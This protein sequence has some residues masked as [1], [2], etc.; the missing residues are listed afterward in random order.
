MYI[1]MCVCVYMCG[2]YRAAL[3]LD[4]HRHAAASRRCPENSTLARMLLQPPPHTKSI[5]ISP[6]P[7]PSSFCPALPLFYCLPRQRDRGRAWL[8]ALALAL[9][10]A[11][12]SCM[13]S[14][15][16]VI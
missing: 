1:H 10:L 12:G 4:M 11:A 13:W 5:F 9:V 3:E 14:G 6:A 2:I 7:S 16:T 15:V 8:L